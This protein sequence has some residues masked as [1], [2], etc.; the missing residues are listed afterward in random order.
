LNPK[1]LVV[2]PEQHDGGLDRCRLDQVEH[3]IFFPP[4]RSDQRLK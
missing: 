2:Q 4:I 1:L 3:S